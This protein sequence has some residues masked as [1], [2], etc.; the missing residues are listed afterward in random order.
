MGSVVVIFF[1]IESFSRGA[2][3]YNL[4]SSEILQQDPNQ[5]EYFLVIFISRKA[6]SFL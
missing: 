1:Q 4:F 3:W 5:K 2:L 6:K